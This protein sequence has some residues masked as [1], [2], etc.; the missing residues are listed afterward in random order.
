MRTAYKVRVY[1]TT[2]QAAVLN[3]TFGCV[4][5]VWNTV[6]AWRQAR[7]RNESE[8]TSYA[9][10]DRYLTELKRD[11]G[12]DF[13]Y[14]VS[15]VPL[16]Q[17]LRHQH[18]AFANFFAGRAKYPRFKSRHGRQSAT[19]TRSAFRWRDGRLF[20][21]KMDHPLEFVWSWP[22]VDPAT[23][24]PTM[25]TI[26]RDVDGR[27]YASLAMEEAAEPEPLPTGGASA[28]IDL[29]VTDFAVL[30]TGQ[31]V[32]NPRHLER[33]ARNLARYQRRMA[34]KQRGSNNRAKAKAKVARA[35]TKVRDA[36]ADFLHRTSTRLVRDHDLIVIEDLNVKGMVRNRHLARAIS[37]AGWGEFRRQ[38]EYKTQRYGRRLVVIDRW[39]PSSKTC[40]A[41]G[42]LLAALSLSTRHWSC[43]DC[44]TRHDRDVNAAKNILAAGRAVS[45][46]GADVSPQGSSLRRSAV[47][48]ETQPARGGIPRP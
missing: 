19:Y 15:S 45:A 11:G 48:Q 36:R 46:C 44:G 16:Q 43:P 2:E 25:V 10:S 17:A 5:L 33:K 42:H 35:H 13:L 27:W 8:T 38:L 22:A 28:G 14:E 21:A 20:L 29:G 6:L 3:R 30:S 37:D 23:I 1:P 7:Y 12:H 26:T 39:Y 40:S 9:Q 4:R 31:K 41:C 18:T 24:N 47:K 32:T 34:R